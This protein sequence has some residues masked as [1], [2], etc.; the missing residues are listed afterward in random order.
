MI[1][2]VERPVLRD[3]GQLHEG[4]GQLRDDVGL[5]EHPR[6]QRHGCHGFQICNDGE[7]DGADFGRG[8]NRLEHV[9]I[10]AREGN[11]RGI[12]LH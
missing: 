4:G 8:E 10:F 5:K 12:V 2:L 3:V 1:G 7:D 9:E 11:L 6:H